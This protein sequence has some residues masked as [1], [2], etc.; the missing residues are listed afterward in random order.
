VDAARL[1]ERDAAV[2]RVIMVD[3]FAPEELSPGAVSVGEKPSGRRQRAMRAVP[4]TS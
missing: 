3:D 1:R 2:H 4:S